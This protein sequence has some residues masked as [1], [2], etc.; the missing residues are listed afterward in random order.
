M[1]R[2]YFKSIRHGNELICNWYESYN[3][4]IINY[5]W[6]ICANQHCFID[7]TTT[8][9]ASTIK[10]DHTIL[11]T[12]K[13]INVHF[14]NVHVF[15]GTY[16]N[17]RSLASWPPLHVLRYVLFRSEEVRHYRCCI[18]RH[19]HTEFRIY[20]YIH[21]NVYTLRCIIRR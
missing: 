12:I 11:N 17:R 13:L 6:I 15:Y 16:E 3:E 4:I 9:K 2:W 10:S 5:I 1:N 21:V 7:Y 14:N 18:Y 8:F 19:T 20:I